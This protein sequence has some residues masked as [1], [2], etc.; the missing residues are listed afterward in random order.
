MI[1]KPKLLEAQIRR[2]QVV[3]AFDEESIAGCPACPVTAGTTA[4]AGT[5][6]PFMTETKRKALLLVSDDAVLGTRL[7]G[8][9]ELAGFAFKQIT[10]PANAVGLAGQDHLVVVLLDLDLPAPAGWEAAEEF[11]RHET[12]PPLILLTGHTNHFDLSAAIHAGA[13]VHKSINPA[14]LLERINWV[15]TEVNSDRVDRKARQLL[16]LRWLR[17]Y[18]WPVPDAPA[19]RF[20]GINE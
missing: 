20:W 19:N 12:C 14:H 15:L 1:M 5:L 10:D 9:A 4:T 11:L 17:P 8:A 16:L 2:D 3:A 13:V 7:I 18:D 6:P